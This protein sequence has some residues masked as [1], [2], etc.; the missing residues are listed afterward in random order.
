MSLSGIFN[1]CRGC[2]VRKQHSVEDPRLQISGMTA[3][4]D[5]GKR[6][7]TLIEL[8]V[9]VLIIG[10]LS[11]IALPQYR[12]AI[13]RTKMV[14]AFTTMHALEQAQQAYYLANGVFTINLEDLGETFPTVTYQSCQWNNS[15]S[16]TVLHCHVV[17]NSIS[18]ETNF[19]SLTGRIMERS[20]QAPINDS[21]RNRVCATYGTYR[22]N[23]GGNSY[24]WLSQN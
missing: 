20:C 13:L 4:F 8:L 19:S 17:L 14:Q 18:L 24:Y 10:I 15:G 2:V 12:L 11:A 6:A 3:L 21:L 16:R 22:F 1:A 23:A 7:F 5:N 9:V